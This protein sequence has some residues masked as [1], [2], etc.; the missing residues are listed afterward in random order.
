MQVN[1]TEQKR[2]VWSV[3]HNGWWRSNRNGYSYERNDAGKYSFDEAAQI[4]KEANILC[5]DSP[6]ETMILDEWFRPV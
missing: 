2:L 1:K 4:V 6:N 5:I 3:E